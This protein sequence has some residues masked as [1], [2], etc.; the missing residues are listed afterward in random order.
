MIRRNASKSIEFDSIDFL[1]PIHPILP[2]FPRHSSAQV[3]AQV[4]VLEKERAEQPVGITFHVAAQGGPVRA[5]AP[6]LTLSPLEIT[7]KKTRGTNNA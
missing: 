5:P 1:R 6:V 2:K 7:A 3:A 4:V